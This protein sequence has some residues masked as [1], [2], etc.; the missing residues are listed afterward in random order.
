[1]YNN[2]NIVFVFLR[3]TYKVYTHTKYTHIY[4]VFQQKFMSAQNFDLIYYF[5]YLN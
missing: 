3:K 2:N 4:M 1:M 5:F